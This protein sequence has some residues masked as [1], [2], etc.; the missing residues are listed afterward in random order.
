[1]SPSGP[2]PGGD[3][4]VRDRRVVLVLLACVAAVLGLNVISGLVPQIDHVLSGAPVLVLAL[5][6]G[7]AAVLILSVGRGGRT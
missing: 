6:A 7:T 1:M 4:R 5:I 3:K 2:I